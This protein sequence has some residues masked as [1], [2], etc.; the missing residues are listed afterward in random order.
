ML[1]TADIPATVRYIEDHA[2]YGCTAL[3]TVTLPDGLTLLEDYAFSGCETI[4]S[5]TIPGSLYN[6]GSYAFYGCDELADVLVKP[7]VREIGKSELHPE[8]TTQNGY[9]FRGCK[10]NMKITLPSTVL[11]V[12][13]YAFDEK[14]TI[15]T[16]DENGQ[17]TETVTAV[18]KYMDAT[19]DYLNRMQQNSFRRYRRKVKT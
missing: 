7:G 17:Q 19:E 16:T 18:Q 5:V 10:D 13:L 4:P 14:K 6:V 12:Y 8:M 15:I 1:E 3:K 9:V 2:F 11:K